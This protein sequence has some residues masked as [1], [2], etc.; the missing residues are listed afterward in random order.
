[1]DEDRPLYAINDQVIVS[2]RYRH[3]EELELL[4]IKAAFDR[5]ELEYDLRFQ[6]AFAQHGIN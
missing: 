1:M 4:A 3:D 6:N 5:E 2:R